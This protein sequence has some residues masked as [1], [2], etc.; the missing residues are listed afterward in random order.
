MKKLLCFS[1]VIV[2]ILS[3]S[4]S[5]L[6]APKEE[7]ITRASAVETIISALYQSDEIKDFDFAQNYCLHESGYIHFVPADYTQKHP[8]LCE[9]YT[10][11]EGSSFSDV[12]SADD[13]TIFV[14][15]AKAMGIINGNGQNQFA[16]HDFTTYSQALKMIVCTISYGHQSAQEKGGYPDGYI[17]VAKE[18]GIIEDITFNGNDKISQK[19]FETILNK[20]I[21]MHNS[22]LN[23]VMIDFTPAASPQRCVDEYAKAVKNRNGAIQYALMD[24]ELREKN[25]ADFNSSWVT[26]VS[27]PWVESYDITK[28]DDLSFTI[29]FHYA[30]STGPAAEQ[31]VQVKLKKAANVYQITDLN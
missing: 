19:D 24:D 2:L 28:I 5:T 14:T 7:Y 21:A 4:I 17:A 9:I 23:V 13:Y 16:P 3:V 20:C 18:L 1:V 27:S 6:A 12:T 29:T 11:V 10:S 26:G 8:I 30:T 15:L 22:P 31:I 25:R